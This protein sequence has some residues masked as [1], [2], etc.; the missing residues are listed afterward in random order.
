ML[1][2]RI[3]K[4]QLNRHRNMVEKLDHLRQ[5]KF[6]ILDQF[7]LKAYDYSKIKVTSGSKKMTDQERAVIAVEKLNREIKALAAIVMPEQMEIEKQIIL[8]D[9]ISNDWRHADI[10]K[11]LYVDGEKMKDI[12]LTY[13]SVDNKNNRNCA[14]GLRDTAIKMLEKVS[15]KPFV[16]IKQTK[17]EDW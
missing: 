5:R 8:L 9:S 1:W 10:L 11:R 4:D 7:G 2:K 6:E 16:E 12:I 17:I 13:Y 14:E 3:K 15:E